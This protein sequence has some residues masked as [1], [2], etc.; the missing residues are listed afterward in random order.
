MADVQASHADS[1][2]HA[3]VLGASGIIGWACVSALL[4]GYPTE[5][6][7]RKVTGLTNRPLDPE[8]RLWPTSSKLQLINGIDLL[9]GDQQQLE[10]TLQ[11]RASIATVTHV[12]FCAYIQDSDPSRET[13]I[14][15]DLLQR[16]IIAIEKLTPNMEFVLLPIGTKV[17]S[18]FTHAIR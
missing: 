13:Q 18:I 6:A 7:F 3:L 8:V 4:S 17:I 16:T 1:D 11:E 5:N 15:G 9:E 10:K 14:N 12:Y 2:R